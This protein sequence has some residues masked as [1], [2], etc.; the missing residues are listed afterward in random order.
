MEKEGQKP[1]PLLWVNE[2]MADVTASESHAHQSGGGGALLGVL[3]HP[4]GQEGFIP[5]PVLQGTV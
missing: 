2:V 1:E 4:P 5:C 3:S